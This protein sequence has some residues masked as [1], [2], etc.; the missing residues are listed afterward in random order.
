MKEQYPNQNIS[1]SL[2]CQQKLGSPHRRFKP[3]RNWSINSPNP[4]T[5]PWNCSSNTWGGK[6]PPIHTTKY[7]VT[8]RTFWGPLNH[9]GWWKDNNN[10]ISVRFSYLSFIGIC[11]LQRFLQT[12]VVWNLALFSLT[13][14]QVDAAH[15]WWLRRDIP[16]P[17]PRLWSAL[18]VQQYTIKR[19]INAS[20]IHSS[21]KRILSLC[22]WALI[23]WLLF[24]FRLSTLWNWTELMFTWL[25]SKWYQPN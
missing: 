24:Y 15:W 12:S 25:P 5:T 11:E 17:L 3:W 10:N 8:H 21:T 6:S 1:S 22:I 7:W 2:S 19:Y 16:P 13:I 4:T 18:G 23:R 9:L 14:I 20:F